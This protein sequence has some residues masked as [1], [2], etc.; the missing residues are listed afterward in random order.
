[1]V[2]PSPIFQSNSGFSSS[3]RLIFIL[4]GL[5]FVL[6]NKKKIGI[7]KSVRLGKRSQMVLPKEVRDWLGVEEG[8]SVIF[9]IGEN[10]VNVVS[11]SQFAKDT[12]GA[13]P[14]AWGEKPGDSDKHL[15]N[16]RSSWE[17]ES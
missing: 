12:F 4:I 11:S 10:G 8:Q 6:M 7:N 17:K 3:G 5:I 16:E 9:Q 15:K 14:K 2:M 13:F 1:M